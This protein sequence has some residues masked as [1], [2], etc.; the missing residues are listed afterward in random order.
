MTQEA[1]ATIYEKKGHIAYLTIN[2]P[3]RMNAM[4]RAVTEGLSQAVMDYRQHTDL[5]VLI[6]TGAGER[7]FCAGGDLK[8]MAE[9][10][11][12]GERLNRPVPTIPI[13]ELIM[14]TYKPII[15]AVNGVAV[16]GGCE[17]SLVCDFRIGTPNTRMGLAEALRGLG[18]MYGSVLLPRTIPRGIALQQLYTGQLLDAATCER[19][20]LINKIVPQNELI[21]YCTEIAEQICECAP[22]SVR[23]MK[24][25]AFKS[26]VMHPLEAFHL[27]V[28]PDV[29]SSE[30]RIEGAKAFTEK[31]KP[32]WKGR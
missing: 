1:P 6:L 11:N 10:A 24:E 15:A 8:D 3:E 14:E 26:Q 9:A 7:A 23:R 25:V 5:R 2:R 22:L 18:A 27:N 30:D 20:G 17:M 21:S 13:F 32:V 28:G 19:W 29:Y 12:A 31:R 16:G 4:G